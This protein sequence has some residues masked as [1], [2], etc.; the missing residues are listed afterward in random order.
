MNNVLVIANPTAGDGSGV[1]LGESLGDVFLK[2]GIGVKLYETTGQDDFKALVQNEMQNDVDTVAILG[3]DGTIS[4]FTAQVSDLEERPEILLVPSGTRN[5]LARAL[6]TELNIDLLLKKVDD[7]LF[8]KQQI[9]VGKIGDRYFISTLSAGSLPEIAWKA[10]DDV[11][12]LFGSF[13]YLLEAVSAISE[14]ETFDL[15]IQTETEE[16]NLKD[17]SLIVVGLSN[18]VFGIPTF[19][20]DAEIDDGELHLYTL[21]TSNLMEEAISLAHHIV[22]NMEAGKKQ[23]NDLSY[24]TSFKEAKIEASAEINF[25]ID[26]EKGPTFPVEL[27]VLHKHFTFLVPETNK[28]KNKKTP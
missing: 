7:E 21:K 10:D 15:I 20:E 17:V 12:E 28:N 16:I 13:G 2:K 22:P 9:D 4:E 3:G 5:N 18:S 23:N 6:D 14:D 1:D 27:D 8:I 24:V 26:G 19:F 25:T 11:K